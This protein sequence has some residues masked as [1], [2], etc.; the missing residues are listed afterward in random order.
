MPH[1]SRIAP[2]RWTRNWLQSESCELLHIDFARLTES[3]SSQSA[4]I[5]DKRVVFRIFVM[6]HLHS[7]TRDALHSR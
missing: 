3:Y 7:R 1:L 2:E 5:I 6:R 4:S